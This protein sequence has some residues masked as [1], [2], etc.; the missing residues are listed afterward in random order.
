M[1]GNSFL[2]ANFVELIL[3]LALCIFFLMIAATLYYVK[4]AELRKI[5]KEFSAAIDYEKI[6]AVTE[7]W[8]NLIQSI[9]KSSTSSHTKGYPRIW[10]SSDDIRDYGINKI[11]SSGRFTASERAAEYRRR[12]KSPSGVIDGVYND[13]YRGNG[14]YNDSY[15]DWEADA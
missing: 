13:M 6:I 4:G 2:D 12:G 3:L 14:S 8:K 1:N 11:R 5:W 10:S 9:L 7:G 15:R